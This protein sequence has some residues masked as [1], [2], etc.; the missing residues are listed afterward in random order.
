MAPKAIVAKAAEMV[1]GCKGAIDI[2][3][4]LASF[5]RFAF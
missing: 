4:M 2:T 5:K 1:G 3:A